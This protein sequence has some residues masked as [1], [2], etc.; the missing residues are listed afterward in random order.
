MDFRDIQEA[1]LK[2]DKRIKL[3]LSEL[4]GMRCCC[5]LSLSQCHST[6]SCPLFFS[7]AFICA[8]FYFIFFWVIFSLSFL[9]TF[10]C[11]CSLSVFQV[12]HIC[13]WK[14]SNIPLVGFACVC[15]FFFFPPTRLLWYL[16]AFHGLF[17]NL[18]GALAYWNL[19]SWERGTQSQPMHV[20][21]ETRAERKAQWFPQAKP[22]SQDQMRPY[23]HIWAQLSTAHPGL[24][25]EDCSF[26][27]KTSKR[28]HAS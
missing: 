23:E 20:K 16:E 10:S 12:A 25:L 8:T 17:S 6:S 22:I 5:I 21:G 11:P 14:S 18:G 24:P 7:F 3:K 9:F 19:W 27:Q 4:T 28:E 15:V 1:N 26:L 2:S 13:D